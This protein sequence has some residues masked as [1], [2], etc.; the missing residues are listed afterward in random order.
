MCSGT[1][2]RSTEH[3][4][5]KTGGGGGGIST[6]WYR[7]LCAALLSCHGITAE[8]EKELFGLAFSQVDASQ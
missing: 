7:A 2:K 6:E 5:R 4:A 1:V 3:G 8:V